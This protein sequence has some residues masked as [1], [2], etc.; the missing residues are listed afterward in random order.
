MFLTLRKVSVLD[1]RIKNMCSN[2]PGNCAAPASAVFDHHGDRKL[3]MIRRGKADEPGV[4]QLLADRPLRNT[5]DIRDLDSRAS[6]GS[7]VP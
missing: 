5:T 7:S 4:I 3:R 1:Q 6:R 2:W